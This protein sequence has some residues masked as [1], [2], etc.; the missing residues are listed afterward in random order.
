LT[1]FAIA[2]DGIRI[3]YE[4]VGEGMPVLLIHGFASSRIQNWKVP[5]WYDT[6][7]GAGYQVIA[8]DCRGHGDSDKP[9]D[10][11]AYHHDLM[12]GDAVAVVHAAGATNV[13][14]M[15]YSMGGYISMRVLL[16]HPELV[17]KVVIG[18]VGEAYFKRQ[19]EQQK[20]IADALLDPDWRRITDSMAK[21]FRFFAEQPGKDLQ[22]LAAYMRCDRSPYTPSELAQSTRPVLVVCG[23]NDAITGA[24]G[25]LAAA[26]A[27]GRAV[28]VARRDHMTT[29]GDKL[30]KQAVLDFFPA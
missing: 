29:V 12:A 20:A 25:P 16:Q 6:L 21:T 8:M 9:H 26:F 2:E 15:G 17:Q 27:D 1:Q 24:P 10:P 7:A 4:V 30:Y 11:T 19:P 23:E 28:T 14:L 18:G 5:G 3:A 13:H 22:A